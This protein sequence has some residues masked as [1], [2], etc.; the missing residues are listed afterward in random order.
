M[1][2]NNENDYSSS[3]CYLYSDD[4][5]E[6][7]EHFE[8]Y[9][10]TDDYT[11]I[12]LAV[13]KG[14]LNS[15]STLLNENNLEKS[16]HGKRML[17]VAAARGHLQIVDLLIKNGAKLN[18]EDFK[19]RTPFYVALQQN[20]VEVAEFLLENGARIDIPR[21]GGRTT[22]RVAIKT[23]NIRIVERLLKQGAMVNVRDDISRMKPID[24]AASLNNIQLVELLLKYGAKM[25]EIDEFRDEQKYVQKRMTALHFAAK[26]GN[27]ELV[28]LLMSNGFYK[29]DVGD[30]HDKTPLGLAIGEHCLGVVKYMLESGSKINEDIPLIDLC[31]TNEDID[32]LKFLLDHGIKQVTDHTKTPLY[33][34]LDRQEYELWKYLITCYSKIDAVLCSKETELH[35]AVRTNDIEKVQEI[36]KKIKVNSLS[37][38]LG[39]FAVYIAVENGNEEM[40]TILLEAGCSVESCFRDKLSPLHIAATFEHTRLVEI[41]LKFGARINSE[42][43]ALSLPLDFA[44]V[45]GNLNM[46]KFLLDSG[47]NPIRKD[48]RISSLRYLLNQN[49]ILETITTSMYHN[50]LKAT[51]LLLIAGDLKHTSDEHVVSLLRDAFSLRVFREGEQTLISDNEEFVN[52]EG[53]KGEFRPDI[54]RCLLNYLDNKL[55][56]EVINL[57]LCDDHINSDI[58]EIIIEY[59][60]YNFIPIDPYFTGCDWTDLFIVNEIKHDY[61]L[62]NITR[63]NMFSS[64]LMENDDELLKLII[65]RLELLKPSCKEIIKYFNSSEYKRKIQ[66]FQNECREQIIIMEKTKVMEE[67]N[68]TFYDI[69]VEST[70]KIASCIRDVK[71]LN[72]NELTYDKFPAYTKFLKL[73]IEKVKCRSELI[74]ISTNCL[75]HYIERNYK[76]QFSTIDLQEILQYLSMCDLRKLSSVFSEFS[77]F[78]KQ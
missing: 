70:D 51:E 3:E 50:L 24:L 71:L 8:N 69:L 43:R 61:R 13:H 32:I 2:S 18:V 59:Y 53:K 37:G 63:N 23:Q 67:L 17:H 49:N 7:Y 48:E 40:L 47:A 73:R 20:K 39:Q 6:E 78:K 4:Y 14:D 30:S 41:L 21:K 52:S 66:K 5:S 42:T 58:S 46:I 38:E 26:F 68:L 35:S 54:V 55:L 22:L 29:I 44:A 19:K 25:D 9:C 45:M 76:I 12:F 72:S 62:L 65:T 34:A 75:Y 27:L 56:K 33:C 36:L 64:K 10:S 15:V 77:H 16:V 60:D 74:D 31:V 57:I 1:S 11:P 28:K